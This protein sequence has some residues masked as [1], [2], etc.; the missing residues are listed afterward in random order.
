MDGERDVERRSRSPSPGA[1]AT[2]QNE[3][4]GKLEKCLR[5][6][7]KCWLALQC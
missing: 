1:I 6:E 3:I 5:R 2:I 4:L 7:A